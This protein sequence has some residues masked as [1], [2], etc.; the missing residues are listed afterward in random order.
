MLLVKYKYL[1]VDS[2][3]KKYPN[4]VKYLKPNNSTKEWLITFIETIKN[5]LNSDCIIFV[6]YLRE[7]VLG[8]EALK[9]EYGVIFPKTLSSEEYSANKLEYDFLRMKS[10]VVGSYVVENKESMDDIFAGKF[11]WLKSTDSFVKM[12][13]SKS[14]NFVD[15]APRKQL[16]FKE[17]VENDSLEITDADIRDMR[18]LTNKFKM[19]MLLQ[20]KTRLKTVVKFCDVLDR[21]YDELINRIDNSL[22]T[23]DTASIMY[24]ADYIA[25]ALGEVN[26]FIMPLIN[27]DKLQNFF[28]IDNSS[29]INIGDNRV[30]VNKREKIR[31]AA[32]IVLDN[33]DYFTSGEYEKIVNPNII[34]T[35]VGETDSKE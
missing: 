16:T 21:L 28:I 4:N 26:Q 22:T 35:E 30:D 17:I 13:V 33:I 20:A 11:D 3:V 1:D 32:E 8:L 12:P 5:S 10:Q 2:F 31:K 6:D 27:N 9:I 14:D 24:T 23:A 7:L 29:V 15:V 19:T 25:K 34:E 18:A